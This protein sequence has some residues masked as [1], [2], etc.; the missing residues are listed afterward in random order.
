[1]P[2]HSCH[3]LG[4]T[5]G[6]KCETY[7][8]PNASS[9]SAIP[10]N[11][12]LVVPG[13]HPCRGL[14]AVP[15]HPCVSVTFQPASGTHLVLLGA[16][17]KSLTKARLV[18]HG[19]QSVSPRSCPITSW[20][21]PGVETTVPMSLGRPSQGEAEQCVPQNVEMMPRVILG[22]NNPSQFFSCLTLQG[23]RRLELPQTSF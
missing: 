8:C 22:V 3:C 23:G 13:S 11:M 20:D 19:Q 16:S 15:G 14:A 4:I 12:C 7:I 9:G 10:S 18:T 21:H 2:C 1:M 6:R 17:E 5:D